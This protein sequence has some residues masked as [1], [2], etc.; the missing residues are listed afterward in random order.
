MP[1]LTTSRMEQLGGHGR[2]HAVPHRAARRRELG[3]EVPELVEAVRP[4]REV[5][6]TVREDR[7]RG[8]AAAHGH[9]HLAHVELAGHRQV[10]E[11]VEV[12]C[13]ALTC[14]RLA[15]GRVERRQLRERERERVRRGGDGERRRVDAA[16]L[17]GIGRDVDERLGRIGHA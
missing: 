4:D 10:A 16:Q 15:R 9:H 8:Q 12:V 11:V 14:V 3:R 17:V 1:L 13:P 5:A 7:I 2:G 6:G